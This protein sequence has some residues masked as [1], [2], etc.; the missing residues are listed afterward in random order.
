MIC[1]EVFRVP[2]QLPIDFVFGEDLCNQFEQ[3]IEDSDKLLLLYTKCKLA[4]S[5]FS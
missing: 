3:S 2:G 4:L 1:I 5:N